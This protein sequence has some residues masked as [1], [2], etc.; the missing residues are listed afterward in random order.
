VEITRKV[1]E[2][3]RLYQHK[4][5]EDYMELADIRMLTREL[6]IAALREELEYTMS[7]SDDCPTE[8]T[9]EIPDESAA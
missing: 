9:A 8:P 1:E 2:E 6:A 5:F 3:I 4:R 7:P